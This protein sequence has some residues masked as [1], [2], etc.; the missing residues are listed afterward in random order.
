MTHYG[1]EQ[2]ADLKIVA[3]MMLECHGSFVSFPQPQL[4]TLKLGSVVTK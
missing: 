4:E 1:T 3:A 2:D